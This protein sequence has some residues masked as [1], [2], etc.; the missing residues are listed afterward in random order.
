MDGGLSVAVIVCCFTE[1]RWDD[2]VA[3][4]ASVHAQS[5][6]PDEVI[7]VVDHAP[8]LAA[9]LRQADANLTVIEN[10]STKGLSGARNTGVGYAT[11]EVVAFLDDDAIAEP[12]WLEE[13]CRPYQSREVVAVGG[14]VEPLWDEARP[15]WFPREFDWVVGCTY[16]GHAGGG[17][18]RNVIGANMSFRREAASAAGGFDERVGRVGRVPSGCEE[19]ELCIRVQQ[20]NPAAV[21][22]YAPDALVGHRVRPERATFAYF[23][24]RCRAEGGSKAAVAGLVGHDQGLS[25]ERNYVWD[26]LPRACRVD[27]AAA[28]RGRDAAG[29]ARVG[30][31]AVGVAWSGWGFTRGRVGRGRV[32]P[33]TV[34]AAE[35]E[36][37]IVLSIDCEDPGAIAPVNSSSG[38]P[39]GRARLLVREAGR[40]AGRLDVELPPDGLSAPELEGIIQRAVKNGEL[41]PQDGL[42]T[43][44]P[45]FNGSAPHVTVVVATMDRPDMLRR[46]LESVLRSSYPSFDVLVVDNHQTATSGRD[47]VAEFGPRVRWVREMRPGLAN[48]HNRALREPTGSILAFT[49]D[50]VVVDEE[51]ITHLIQGF[52]EGRDV[53]CVTGLIFPLELET[54][55]QDL[56]ERSVGFDK[57][58]ERQVFR[59][60]DTGRGRLFPYAAGT[61]GSGANMA[62]RL[63]VL[64]AI[65]GFD[66]SLGTG[67]PALGGDDL[68]AFF[69]VVASGYALVYEPAAVIFHAHRREE[70]ALSRQAYGYGAGLTAYLTRVIVERPARLLDISRRLPSGLRYGLSADSGKNAGRPG[71]YPRALV[72]KERF[73]MLVGPARYLQSRRRN[74]DA[75]VGAEVSGPVQ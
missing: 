55:S 40:P 56:V 73:G 39:Y 8:P 68:A 75:R 30:A 6:Q 3:A 64:R 37:A 41:Q 60:V 74:A 28:L 71:D 17:P 51:W 7:V 70:A 20:R 12:S 25:S 27:L 32:R 53:G 35:F 67:T 23:R 44:Q 54:P 69:D 15:S 61:F 4:L 62:F 43:E 57:G 11:A 52:A 19:T 1:D 36:P 66:P 46:C 72:R 59:S 21:V 65:G 45:R 50:D 10:A 22:W 49:D 29:L 5:L 2:I 34:T 24:A 16:A 48:A 14:R 9:R 18:V 58:Y 63:D 42:G 47:V 38:A 26:T 31:R 13:L 33:V